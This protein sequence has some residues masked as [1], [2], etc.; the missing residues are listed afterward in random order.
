MLGA[1]GSRRHNLAKDLSRRLAID[2]GYLSRIVNRLVE[3]DLARRVAAKDG[4]QSPL[5]ATGLGRALLRRLARHRDR[6]A[7]RLLKPLPP[8]GAAALVKAIELVRHS[9]RPEDASPEDPSSGN[10]PGAE[11]DFRFRTVRPGDVA[12]LAHRLVEAASGAAEHRILVRAAAFLDGFNRA[13][14]IGWIAERDRGFAAAC[15]LKGTTA[16]QAELTL[17]HVEPQARGAALA[18][19]LIGHCLTFARF[20]KYAQVTARVMA[21][22]S[23]IEDALEALEFRLVRGAKDAPGPGRLWAKRL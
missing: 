15:L 12:L 17:I 3:L 1:L 23:E 16:D 9:L 18:G 19:T 10:E 13:R 14:D 2:K 4:R 11:T 8:A 5:A 6:D 20:A 7:A 22:Q 21:S